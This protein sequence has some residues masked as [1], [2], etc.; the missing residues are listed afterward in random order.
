MKFLPN[1]F[2]QGSAKIDAV[3]DDLILLK[4]PET[5]R[6]GMTAE[7]VLRCAILRQYRNLTYTAPGH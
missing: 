2:F 3:Y 5:G 7:Q 6:T 1:N 4:D